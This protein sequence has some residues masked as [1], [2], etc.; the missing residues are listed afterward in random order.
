MYSNTR[1]SPI[2]DATIVVAARDVMAADFA[3]E[4][5]LLNLRDGVYYGVEDVGARVWALLQSPIA[6]SA[7]LETIAEEFDVDSPRCER[8][9]RAFVDALV[10]RG[11]ADVCADAR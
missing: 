7:I 4:V 3:P 5:V 2:S 10:A 1:V 11:L 8:E 9:V 6:V